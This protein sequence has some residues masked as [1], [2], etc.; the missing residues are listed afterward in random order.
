MIYGHSAFQEPFRMESCIDLFGP[1][2]IFQQVASSVA[3]LFMLRVA[4][5]VFLLCTYDD[6]I[7]RAFSST[8]C[9][10]SNSISGNQQILYLSRPGFSPIGKEELCPSDQIYVACFY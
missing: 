1:R 2:S 4:N 8:P 9:N 7:V 5:Y 3:S 10:S 6:L